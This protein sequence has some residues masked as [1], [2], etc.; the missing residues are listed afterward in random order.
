MLGDVMFSDDELSTLPV[1]VTRKDGA[2]LVSKYFFTVNHR[3]LER[4]PLALQRLNGKAHV[5][6]RELFEYAAARVAE[7]PA[8]RSIRR[9]AEEQNAA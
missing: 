6:T 4:W 3:T 8:I 9:A 7:A 1:R 2:K 5:E